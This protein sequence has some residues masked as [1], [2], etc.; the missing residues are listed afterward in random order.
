MIWIVVFAIFLASY[1]LGSVPSGL[2]ISK[3]HG[4]DIREHG[5]RNI[6]ATNVWRVMG[7]KWGLVA[8]FCDTFKGWFAVTLGVAIAARFPVTEQLLHGHTAEHFLP[9]DYAGITAALGC[10]LGHNFPVWLRFK[11]GKGVA[12]SL[13]VIIGMMPL[14]SL[15]IFAVWGVVLKVS[16]YVSLASLIAAASL[17]VA[18]I[19]LMFFGPAHGWAAVH[20]WANFYF[21]VAAAALVIKRHMPNI[22]RLCAGT[23]LRFGTP[24]PAVQEKSEP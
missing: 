14:A 11:G 18:V 19:G 15:I 22:Q 20:G 6:G 9:A 2:F 8:F 21:A 23:E 3:A 24:K 1:L 13:G 16:R 5:S 17:P 12:T 7:K 10:I 4:M